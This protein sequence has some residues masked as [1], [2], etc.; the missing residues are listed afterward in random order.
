[1]QD[2]LLQYGLFLAKTLTWVVAI[3]AVVALI[4]NVIREGRGQV[5]ERLH[6]GALVF[7]NLVEH[8]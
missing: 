3:V 5:G 4:A 7:V 6:H 2:L 1:M 8:G